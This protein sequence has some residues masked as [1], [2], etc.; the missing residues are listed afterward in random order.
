MRRHGL[1]SKPKPLSKYDAENESRPTG[2]HM[3]NRASRKINCF[4]G[5]FGIPNTIH[6]PI[7]SPNHVSEREINHDHPEG[8]EEQDGG[9]LHAFRNRAHDQ[10]GSDDREH[11]LIHG[12]HIM[13]NPVGIV[14]VRSGCDVLQEGELLEIADDRSSAIRKDE[15]VAEGP[16]HEGH[17]ACYAKALRK[18]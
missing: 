14:R 1:F 3:H 18:D 13:G 2:G 16:P 12:E 5:S 17:Q 15:A 8:H 10:R 6:Q 11:H 7:D 4:N 9:E